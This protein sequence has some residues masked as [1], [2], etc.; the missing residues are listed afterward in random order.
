MNATVLM[1]MLPLVRFLK[2]AILAWHR[3]PQSKRLVQLQMETRLSRRPEMRWL[4]A[5]RLGIAG[6]IPPD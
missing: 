1:V 3:Q 4:D 2:K 5:K 6:R